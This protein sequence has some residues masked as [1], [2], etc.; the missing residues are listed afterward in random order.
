V[1][2]VGGPAPTW[3]V[4]ADGVIELDLDRDGEAVVYP[5]GSRPDF[6]IA[7]VQVTEPAE[8]WGLPA[9]PQTGAATPVDLVGHFDN[10]AITT[11]MYYGDGDFDGTG[12]TYPMAQLPQTGQ[13]EDDGITFSFTNGSEGSNNN[14]IAAGQKVSVPAG[15]YAKLHVLGS[16]D[17]ADVTVPA[18]FGYAD[19][20]TAK[21][22]I[23][24]T[25]WLSGPK[26]GET[27]AVRTGQIHTRTGPLSTKAAIFHQRVALDPAKELSSVTLGAPSGTA[28][29]HIFALTL[30]KNS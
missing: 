30:E 11:E 4:V 16:G 3:R 13:T 25:A 14:L 21:A 2:G 19:G 18:E 10:D 15:S 8:R 24:L 22:D 7:P 20:S 23:R 29:A 1:A 6:E 9:L 28:R 26:Y 5:A 17:T 12:R 27:E